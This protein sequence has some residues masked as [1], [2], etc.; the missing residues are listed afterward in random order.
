MSEVAYQPPDSSGS[1]P[2]TRYTSPATTP[3]T[4]GG[5]TTAVRYVKSAPSTSSATA[6]V[7]I[8]SVLA[9]STT[10]PVLR[11][12]IRRP[13]SEIAAHDWSLIMPSNG[14]TPCTKAPR[15]SSRDSSPAARR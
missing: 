6:A 1:P 11:S 8:L 13:S 7:R 15:L 5:P 9:G 12:P 10:D 2:P 3:F 14:W 4:G